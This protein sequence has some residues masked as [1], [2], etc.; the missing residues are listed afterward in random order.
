VDLEHL[1]EELRLTNARLRWT[2]GGISSGAPTPHAHPSDEMSRH[3]Y[4]VHAMRAWARSNGLTD[5]STGVVG[6]GAQKGKLFLTSVRARATSEP[7]GPDQT[8]MVSRSLLRWRTS[9]PSKR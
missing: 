8:S 6:N 3:H 2:A 9:L 4:L 5:V 1:S 7:N